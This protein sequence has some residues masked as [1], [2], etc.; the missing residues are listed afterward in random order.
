LGVDLRSNDTDITEGR[1]YADLI[2][3]VGEEM[4][5]W[6]RFTSDWQSLQH[7]AWRHG[8]GSQK[9]GKGG[10]QGLKLIEFGS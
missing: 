2:Q 4:D 5:G 9:V 8:K 7:T 6:E 3:T 1:V 10:L